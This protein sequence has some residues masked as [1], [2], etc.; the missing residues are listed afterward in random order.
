LPFHRLSSPGQCPTNRSRRDAPR[1]SAA[2]PW[3][4]IAPLSWVVR[5]FI[6]CFVAQRA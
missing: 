5:R 2:L 4:L 6:C 1:A 3:S